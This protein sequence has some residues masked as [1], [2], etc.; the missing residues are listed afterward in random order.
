MLNWL[1]FGSVAEEVLRE[2]PVPVMILRPRR[3]KETPDHLTMAKTNHLS[4]LQTPQMPDVAG[5]VLS[6]N[7]E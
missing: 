3:F 6:Y 1:M 4:S 2:A 7:I 5:E